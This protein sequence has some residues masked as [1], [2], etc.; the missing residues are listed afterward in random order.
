MSVSVDFSEAGEILIAR[1]EGSFDPESDELFDRTVAQ[2]SREGGFQR[3]LIDFR[4]VDG[5]PAA[6]ESYHASA[7][8]HERGFTRTIKLAFVDRI[9]FKEANEFYAL[10]ARNRGF[11]VRHFYNEDEAFAWLQA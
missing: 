10:V 5:M 11:T 7:T 2:K 8:L 6:T 9:E 1:A 3:I 4:K